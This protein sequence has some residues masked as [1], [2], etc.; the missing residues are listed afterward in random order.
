MMTNRTYDWL[1]ICL[2]M[3]SEYLPVEV[4]TKA[5]SKRY[6]DINP[7]IVCVMELSGLTRKPGTTERADYLNDFL[8]DFI[9]IFNAK[10]TE[11]ADGESDGENNFDN[12]K[13][14][15]LKLVLI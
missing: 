12:A 2:D 8:K 11:S 14:I 13:L 5:E 7:H 10:V 6:W 3:M 15:G 1:G 4:V 9:R